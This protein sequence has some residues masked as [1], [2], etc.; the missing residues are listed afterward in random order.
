MHQFLAADCSAVELFRYA[1]AMSSSRADSV[2]V[3]CIQ[4]DKAC[5]TSTVLMYTYHTHLIS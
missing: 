2:L 5:I 3:G 4:L 1:E